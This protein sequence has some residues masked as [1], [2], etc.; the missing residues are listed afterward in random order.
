MKIF[1]VDDDPMLRF[2]LADALQ[3]ERDT[4]VEFGTGTSML[5]ALDQEPD[6]IFL[7]IEM[8]GIDG[9]SACR[10]LRQ[11]GN[12]H[13]QV[14]FISSDDTLESR[15][16][17]YDAGAADFLTKP[18]ATEDVLAKTSVVRNRH[19]QFGTL[20]NDA[21]FAQ[22][23][24]FTAMSSMAELGVVLE[25]L[26]ASFACADLDSLG[27][28]LVETLAQYGLDGII[29]LRTPET[30]RCYSGRG[31]CTQ[32]QMSI[33]AHAQGLERIFRFRSNLSVNYPH[34]TLV[35]TNLADDEERIG[36][37]RD[38][39]AV[40]AEGADARLQSLV[41]E[42]RRVAQ[43]SGIAQALTDLTQML[44]EI[45]RI[46]AANRVRAMEIESNFLTELTAA[47]AFLGLTDAQEDTLASLATRM[48]TQLAEMRD[49]DSSVSSRLRAIS[50]QL[51]TLV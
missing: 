48:H 10:Q 11:Q 34:V 42:Q 9:I 45:E 3:D 27:A 46:Q 47:F 33:L 28:R 16:A 8:P 29:Q 31:A 32:M 7:D 43:G 30:S 21:Q 51:G 19:A 50:A 39:L 20:S 36:R 35:V 37:L 2:L 4:L 40:L 26:R 18:F 24:A 49:Q 1:V 12:T 6:L 13:A 25:F 14:I 5:A 22:N 44:T 38:N 41:T 15:L 17:A 23:A